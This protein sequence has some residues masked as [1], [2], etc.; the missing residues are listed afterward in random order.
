MRAKYMKFQIYL[1][2]W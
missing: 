1:S 2:I